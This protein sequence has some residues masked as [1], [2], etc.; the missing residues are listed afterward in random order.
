MK[1][2]FIFLIKI[3]I[4]LIEQTSSIN[5]TCY[6]QH[7]VSQAYGTNGTSP[8]THFNVSVNQLSA[9]KIWTATD[10]CATSITGIE[11]DFKNGS[12]WLFGKSISGGGCS[13]LTM[14]S[15]NVNLE[16]NYITQVN[17]NADCA[18]MWIASIQFQ[19]YNFQ[20][21]ITSITTQIGGNWGTS[22]YLNSSITA[23]TDFKIT[24]FYGI[25]D[26]SGVTYPGAFLRRLQFG[27]SYCPL[28]TTITS[29]LTIHSATTASSLTTDS[30]VETKTINTTMDTTM[31]TTTTRSITEITTKSITTPDTKAN[32]STTN[33]VNK[34]TLILTIETT[35]IISTMDT[36][37]RISLKETTTTSSNSHSVI[38]TTITMDMT[39]TSS[40]METTPNSS[41]TEPFTTTT[42]SSISYFIIRN[43]L[44]FLS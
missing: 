44:I 18:T 36:T 23:S 38:T 4:L 25:I 11:F 22:Y 29:P 33:S 39:T 9:I 35:T 41:T 14:S 3:L 12:T 31:D 7:S 43:K 28:S 19:L 24:N 27:Y 13:T 6:T 32:S 26:Q 17:I 30:V 2:Y 20:T 8:N 42:K 16:N 40:T 1:I 34:T 37:T 21:N 10:N 5:L 15:L